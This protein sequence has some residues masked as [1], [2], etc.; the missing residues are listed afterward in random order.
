MGY[1][2]HRSPYHPYRRPPRS[3]F[4]GILLMGLMFLVFSKAF[5]FL[6]LLGFLLLGFIFFGKFAAYSR[7]DDPRRSWRAAPWSCE[8][9]D[10][11]A[12]GDGFDS[13]AKRKNDDDVI[14]VNKRKN[15]DPAF[16][17]TFDGERLEVIRE[18]DAHN[19]K[20]GDDDTIRYV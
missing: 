3:I 5:F 18:D 4:P 9:D 15:D 19:G 8:R 1:P 20:L 17:E 11:G 13:K 12:Y 16:F 14:V 10:D 6:P 2:R 7:G